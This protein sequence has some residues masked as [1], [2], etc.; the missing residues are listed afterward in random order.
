M[1]SANNPVSGA[2][3]RGQRTEVSSQE[4]VVRSQKSEVRSR[5]RRDAVLRNAEVSDPVRCARGSDPAPALDR[6][7]PGL[8]IFSAQPSG[9]SAPRSPLIAD[10]WP[11]TSGRSFTLIELLVVIAIIGILA[12][13]LLPVLGTA[14]NTA[15]KISCASN[16]RQLAICWSLYIE[17]YNEGLPAKDTAVWDGINAGAGKW[18]NIMSNYLKTGFVNN[19]IIAKSF[20]VCPK[21]PVINPWYT[22]G[23][24]SYGMLANGIGGLSQAPSGLGY[25]NT[26][27]RRFS[28]VR[29][30]SAQIAFADSWLIGSGRP[31]LGFFAIYAGDVELR[32]L[33]QANILFCDGHVESKDWRFRIPTGNWTV[34]PPWGNP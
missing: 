12:A 30:P 19:R 20:L 28:Q 1:L 9:L 16:E 3:V 26:L 4:S 22:A 31:D 27:Y 2:E 6:R 18:V 15:H 25:S 33:N 5:V 13:L 32:H 34:L 7:S 21:K 24:V 11:L 17:D 14:Q 8:A 10:R 23:Y 29:S